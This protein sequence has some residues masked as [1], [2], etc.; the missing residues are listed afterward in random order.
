MD[1]LK[2]Q[3]EELEH[4]KAEQ[5]RHR[6]QLEENRTRALEKKKQT[7]YLVSVGKLVYELLPDADKRTEEEIRDIL[8]TVL[9]HVPKKD[10]T[11]CS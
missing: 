6:K 7:R 2:Q 1:H 10:S 3:W 9:S 5:A 11:Q 4:L 8:I